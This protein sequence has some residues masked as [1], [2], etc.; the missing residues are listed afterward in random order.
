MKYRKVMDSYLR[1]GFARKLSEGE[2]NKESKTHLYLPHH[3]VT[4]PTK[5]GKVRTVFDAAAECEGTSLNK[6]LLTGPDVANNLV[7]VLLCFRQRKIAFAADIEKMF[8]QIRMREEDQDSLSFLWWTNRYDNP[9]D[10]YDMQVHIFGAASSPCIA[11]STLRRVAD[12]NAEE[13]SSS[14]IT[15]VKKNFYV[16][17][18]LPSEN[19]EQSTISLAH[20]MVELLAQGRFNL[21]KF[22]SNSKR[23]LSA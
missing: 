5:P 8:H 21:T 16:D 13:Y 15:A 7:C 23:L 19:D 22:M 14:V 2:L 3:P 18:A 17:D 12:N 11:N 20:D 1:S 6:N 4:S 10:T 9:P